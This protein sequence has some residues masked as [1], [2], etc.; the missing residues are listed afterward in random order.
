MRRLCGLEAT[1]GLWCGGWKLN[2]LGDVSSVVGAGSGGGS[3][4]NAGAHVL[5]CYAKKFVLC[6]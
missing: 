5:A 4:G 6:P 1:A 2:V 3:G